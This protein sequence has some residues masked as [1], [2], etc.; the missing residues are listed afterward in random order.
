[1]E[2]ESA[3]RL[4]SFVLIFI[5]VALWKILLPRGP[6]TTSKKWRWFSSLSIVAINPVLVR[7]VFP[8]LAVGAAQTAQNNGWGLLNHFGTPNV[9]A[10]VVGIVALDLVIYMQRY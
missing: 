10:L 6:L 7:M 8:V 4:I 3:I 5:L 1:M 9:I 2:Y